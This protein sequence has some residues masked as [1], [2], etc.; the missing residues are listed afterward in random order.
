MFRVG[1]ITF[2][3]MRSVPDNIAAE[4]VKG[5]DRLDMTFG[6][7]TMDDVAAA[8]GIPRATIYYYF[9]SK[10]DVLRFVHQS[11]LAE[12][13]ATVRADDE[14]TARERLTTL[15]RR[16]VTHIARH[17]GTAQLFVAN[18]GELGE[19][20]ELT[21]RFDPLAEELEVLLRDGVRT[22]EIEVVDL[23]RAAL[24]ISAMAHATATRVVL[25]DEHPDA[26]ELADWL[27][28]MIWR[29][30]GSPAL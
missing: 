10:T 26:D 8:S 20:S 17:R 2:S 18:L 29:G 15:L 23:P 13:R 22:A 19:W 27:V 3:P 30:I 12:Y 14:G 11:L 21:S 25:A 5:A 24:A 7:A 9:R 28:G 16:L 4:L 6:D 1:R